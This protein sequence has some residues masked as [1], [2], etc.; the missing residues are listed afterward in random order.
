[1]RT[2]WPEWLAIFL[3]QTEMLMTDARFPR[4][5]RDACLASLARAMS[6]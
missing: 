3:W 1:M 2:P 4:A 6:A 5:N